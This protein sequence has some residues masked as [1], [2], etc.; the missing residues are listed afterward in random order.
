VR[1]P[2]ALLAAASAAYAVV[3][4]AA[5]PALAD[6]AAP[7]YPGDP[8]GVPT[9]P[10]KD[11]YIEHEDLSM[12]LT[13]VAGNNPQSAIV[14]A[15][16]KLRN[17][18]GPRNIEL[19][20]VT[21][22]TNVSG[23]QVKLDGIQVSSTLSTLGPSPPSWQPPAGTPA[24]GGG[25]D[26]R[27]VENAPVTVTFHIALGAGEHTMVSRYRPIPS[28]YSGDATAYEPVYWQLAFVL[29]PARQWEG[30]GDLDV[31]VMVPAGWKAASRPALS[32]SGDTLSG[33]FN[34]IPSDSIALTTEMASP[35]DPT[36][37]VLEFGLIALAIATL[38]AGA[39]IGA[40]AGW[41][42]VL[43]GVLLISPS[44][45]AALG[46]AMFVASE[47]GGSIPPAQQS[48]WGAKGFILLAPWNA[49][50]GFS[51]GL[52]VGQLAL[53]LG[54]LAGRLVRRLRPQARPPA[55]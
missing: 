55:P 32:R 7:W 29:A 25:P 3:V 51:A 42:V 28:K 8:V 41:Q 4:L 40:R 38:V 48:W 18:G 26:L 10:V 50:K 45:A 54:L 21:A 2:T 30:F 47:P 9:G 31:T 43:A 46:S 24:I 39:L 35:G 27:Y 37:P 33:H 22:S 44:L 20:F 6:A 11:V 13:G 52:L 15:T 34:G 19:V 23:V 5:L 14:V 17:D 49:I 1:I 12:D 16:Y 36:A 53:L